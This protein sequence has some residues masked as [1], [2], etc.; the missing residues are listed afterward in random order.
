[1]VRISRFFEGAGTIVLVARSVPSSSKLQ[2]VSL[3]E[4][5]TGATIKIF[6]ADASSLEQMQALYADK[7][8]K[9]PSMAGMVLTAMVLHDQLI[10]Q[11]D[12][13]SF[14]KVMAP[15]VTGMM[16]KLFIQSYFIIVY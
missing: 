9:L 14:Y 11:V 5:E 2:E 1:M 6:Q 13:D 3:L 8:V 4:K 7:L 12:S 16:F 10:P 15:K